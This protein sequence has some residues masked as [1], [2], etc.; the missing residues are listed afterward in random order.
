MSV[1]ILM[2]RGQFT[3]EPLFELQDCVHTTH[4]ADAGDQYQHTM[5][6]QLSCKHHHGLHTA[7]LRNFL[8][9]TR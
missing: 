6:A 8:S 3:Q 2:G 4:G 5:L 9:R 7:A 1:M